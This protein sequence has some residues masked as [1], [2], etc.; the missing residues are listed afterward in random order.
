MHMQWDMYTY[1]HPCGE[2]IYVHVHTHMHEIV[3][4]YNNM[5]TH[6]YQLYRMYTMY[7]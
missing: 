1:V 6:V 3:H 5:C 4:N 2:C 7:Q